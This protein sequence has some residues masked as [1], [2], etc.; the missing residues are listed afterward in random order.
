M[1]S[2]PVKQALK[3]GKTVLG[4]SY[5]QLRD[6]E[7][8]RL[9]KAAGFDYAYLDGEHGGFGI[10]TIQNICRIGDLCGLTIFTRVANMTY[11]MI[12]RALDCGSDG[13]IFP[14]VESPE[15]LE[16]AVSW[17]KFPPAGVRGFGLTV[18][19]A[20]YE[21]VTI[22]QMIAHRNENGMIILQI[23]TVKA[24]EAREELLSVPGLDVVMVGP[25]DLSISLG[26]PGEFEH[27]R[28]IDAIDKIR[29]TCNAKDI[30]PGI[31]CRG[32]A[33]SKFC[34]DRGFRFLGTSNE[35]NLLLEKA[36]ETVAALR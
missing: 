20:N 21:A 2:N 27:P 19:Q 22:P 24:L 32:V 11:E 33:L 15:L 16:Q 1:R 18:M 35:W 23:E 34:R 25:V 26:I 31:Q 5:G 17:C 13:I 28:F 3:E 7:I 4:T 36:K 9:L 12:A 14:R 6:P 10:E 29:D 30:A 8:T